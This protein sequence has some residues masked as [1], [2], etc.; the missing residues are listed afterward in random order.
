M[1]PIYS[2]LNIVDIKVK[3]YTV[4]YSKNTEMILNSIECFIFL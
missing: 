4:L 2:S 3:S 1:Q